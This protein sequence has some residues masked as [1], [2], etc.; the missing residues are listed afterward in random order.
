MFPNQVKQPVHKMIQSFLKKLIIIYKSKKTNSIK[1][2]EITQIKYKI[3]Q[4]HLITLQMIKTH[5]VFTF[6][7]QLEIMSRII[8]IN[9][10]H[11]KSNP[12]LD[13]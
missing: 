13:F 3:Q 1:E 11:K 2:A 5:Q 7:L 4:Y 8:L 6:L 10:K 12:K 9:N